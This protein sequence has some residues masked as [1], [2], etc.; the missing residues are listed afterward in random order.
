MSQINSKHRG[1][2]QG[3]I[4]PPSDKSISHRA[5]MFA[6]LA[7]GNSTIRNFLQAEDP[8][9]TLEAFRQM[10]IEIDDSDKNGI[11]V[12]G[13]G[14]KGLSAPA[15]VIDCGNS[16]TTMRLMS[17]VLAA[18]SFSSVLTG[19]EF[20]LKRPMGRIIKPLA[21]M[22]AHIVSE[23]GGY[24]PLNINGG[25]LRPVKYNSPIASAQVKSA[26]LLSG[27]YCDGRTTVIEPGKSRD[28]TERMLKSCGADIIINGLEVSIQ[29]T[30]G[31]APFDITIPGDLSSAAFFIVA[32]LIVPGSEIVVKN[33][34]IN[35]SRTGIIEIL[36]K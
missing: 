26:I 20:L 19:D 23:K 36:Q 2:L 24:P 33:V 3:E 11:I 10:G 28:H 9:R 29:G 32:A 13:K 25:T 18:Q 5:V 6:S 21:E 35:P 22:G 8:L 17:G 30:K 31:L 7:E 16:G 27:L 4:T 15:D 34:G 1:P 12:K 14:L